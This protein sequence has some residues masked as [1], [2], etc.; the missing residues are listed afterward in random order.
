MK[1]QLS[2]SISH[3]LQLLIQVKTLKQ[4]MKDDIAK[5]II[6]KHGSPLLISEHEAIVSNIKR[7]AADAHSKVL[8]SMGILLESKYPMFLFAIFCFL[9]KLLAQIL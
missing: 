9:F 8:E 2:M 7:K 4:K 1:L 5:A 6:A 3:N